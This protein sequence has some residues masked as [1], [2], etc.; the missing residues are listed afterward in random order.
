MTSSTAETRPACLPGTHPEPAANPLV[1]LA[2]ESEECVANNWD[3]VSRAIN[4]RLRELGWSQGEL[5]E[6]S[7]VSSA[8]VREIQRNTV[9]RKRSPRTLE[10]LSAAVGWHQ[11]HLDAVLH[12]KHP[13]E[14]ERTAP[15]QGELAER[16]DAL[17]G[18]L[19]TIVAKLDDLKADLATVLEHVRPGGAKSSGER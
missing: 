9:N 6:R 19:D 18:R 10:A 2:S 4:D 15:S 14:P 11:G 12:G 16:M 8:I 1:S 7:H 3:A 5:V 17:E 13:P